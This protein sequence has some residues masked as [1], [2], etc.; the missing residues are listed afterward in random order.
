MI[1]WARE[2]SRGIAVEEGG[3]STVKP[4]NDCI[5]GGEATPEWLACNGGWQYQCE[6][7]I[8]NLYQHI[9]RR[10]DNNTT[11]LQPPHAR[12]AYLTLHNTFCHT[13]AA[14]WDAI[15]GSLADY[16]R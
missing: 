12:D 13:R 15:F 5:Y 10:R 6:D 1:S 2:E 16:V 8:T 14:T 3:E 11:S 4:S 9:I 7:I